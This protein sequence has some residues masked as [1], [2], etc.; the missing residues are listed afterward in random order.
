[1]KD[2]RG[3]G[4]LIGNRL[5]GIGSQLITVP[6]NGF[7]PP[8]S[9]ELILSNSIELKQVNSPGFKVLELWAGQSFA[10]FKT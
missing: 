8:N 2:A 3:V 5:Y 7:I 4:S 6:A 1:M 9:G 10:V